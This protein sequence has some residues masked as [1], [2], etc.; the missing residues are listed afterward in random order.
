MRG[1]KQQL[2]ES[3]KK[4]LRDLVINGED[5][6]GKIFSLD[7]R[8]KTHFTARSIDADMIDGGAS[9]FRLAEIN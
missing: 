7:E 5:Y 6:N 3:K 1:T 8:T 4:K 2:C 9:S